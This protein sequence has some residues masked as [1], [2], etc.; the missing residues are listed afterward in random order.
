[1]IGIALA[2]LPALLAAGEPTVRVD[3]DNVSIT[4]S[5]RVMIA[6]EPIV[7]ADG[8][9]VIHITGDDIIVEF[10]LP[11]LDGAV[12]GQTPDAFEGI[13]IRITGDRVTLRGAA[14]SGY[15]VAIHAS[16]ADGLTIEECDVSGNFRQ[17]LKS[18]PQAEDGDDWLWPHVNDDNEWMTRYGAGIYLEDSTGVTIRRV[19]ARRGQNGIILDRITDSRVYDNDCS[20]LS[21]WGLALWRSRRNVITRNAFDFCIRG[22]SHG[23]YNRGQDSAGILMFEQCCDNV[24][25]ENSATHGGDGLFG[26]AGREALGEAN[27][28]DELDWYERRGNND[29]LLLAND[30]SYAAAHGIEMTFSFGNRMHHN[31]LVGN[32]ICGVWGGY[33]Q[34]TRIAGNLFRQNGE[35]GYGLE[36]GGVNIEHGRNNRIEHNTFIEN[37]CGVHLWWDNDESLLKQP[38][39]RV[40]E[41]GST[42]NRI[43]CNTFNDD[44]IAIHLRETTDTRI[45]GNELTN[46]ERPNDFGDRRQLMLEMDCGEF[47]PPSSFE[48]PRFGNTRPVGARPELRGREHI[49]MTEWGPYDWQSPLLHLIERGSHRHVYRLLG[50]GPDAGRAEVDAPDVIEFAR[51]DPDRLVLRLST[52]NT[53]SPYTVRVPIDGGA[54]TRTGTLV[55]ARWVV[56]VFPYE[57]DPREDVKAWRAEA[58]DEPY[59]MH[60]DVLDLRFGMGGLSEAMD[61]PAALP[62]DRFGTFASTSLRFPAG[63][64]RL[65]TVSDDGIRLW[66]D[67]SLV[68]DDWT[69]HAPTTHEYEFTLDEARTMPI[70]VEHFELNGYAILTLDIESAE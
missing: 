56:R 51:L 10:A 23:V 12:E 5:C 66:L 29:N 20:F 42:D 67:G 65:R 27:P 25:A 26:F 50:D 17:R 1:M 36:R 30:F 46:V 44:A 54:L 43:L 9:G 70:R 3:R 39:A 2:L 7:D 52:P 8:N 58:G 61:L 53:I 19:T 62:R 31:R 41:H 38:W 69:W 28:R 22:Y 35:R 45:G 21:G 59:T 64:W 32:A 4:E 14:V 47:P 11:P 63:A 40:N 15:K 16:G 37:E 48:A 33:S 57:T 18:T 55:N 13:G 24:I 68:I 34:D 60:A 6:A 49:I